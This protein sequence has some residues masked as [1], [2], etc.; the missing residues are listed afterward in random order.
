ML[1]Q[2]QTWHNRIPYECGIVDLQV[3]GLS[4]ERYVCATYRKDAYLPPVA[5]R[6]IEIL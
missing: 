1:D 3:R 6:F 5:F 4:A 2:Y